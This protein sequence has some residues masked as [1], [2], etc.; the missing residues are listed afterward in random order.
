MEDSS[1]FLESQALLQGPGSAGLGASQGQGREGLAV[2][3]VT[4]AHL[5][6]QPPGT[7][8]TLWGGALRAG[9]CCAAE[10]S[11]VS[12]SSRFVLPACLPHIPAGRG[13]IKQQQKKVLLPKPWSSPGPALP[14]CNRHFPFLP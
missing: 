1:S 11:L 4:R 6:A 13:E 9:A 2:F 12:Q 3:A 5:G 10:N 8:P 14:G 7:A